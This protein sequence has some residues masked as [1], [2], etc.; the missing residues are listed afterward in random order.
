MIPI[1]KKNLEAVGLHK[2]EVS[3]LLVLL[4]NSPMLV[5]RIARGAKLNRTT[6]YG[7]LKMLSEKGLASS[8]RK[9]GALRYQ[10]IPPDQLPSYIERRREM[11]A[12]TK[13]QIAEMIPQLNLIR[14][15]G[16]TLPRVQFFEGEEGVKQAYEDTLENN[17][18][19]KLLDIT[20][21]DAVFKHFGEKWVRYYLEKRKRLDITCID[22][23][24]ESAWA[25]KSREEDKKYLRETKFLPARY[26]FD[27]ELS[28]YDDK[29]GIFSY[30]QE[31]PVA[32]I[33]EDATISDMMKKLF[34]CLE[35]VAQ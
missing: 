21:V 5:S 12:E 17:R 14:S 33:V 11:L 24:P 6:T 31:T 32:L 27:A 10:S 20:G 25:H 30:S 28:L 29:V 9:Q 26:A 13:K 23:A 16:K 2:N 34:T 7:V 1:L 18:E 35:T 22:L 8:A 3:I 15:K 19:K 4:E